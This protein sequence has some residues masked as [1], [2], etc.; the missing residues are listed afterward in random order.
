MRFEPARID[1]RRGDVV[2]F[3]QTGSIPHNVQ[4]VRNS[5]PA[6][7]DIGDYWTGPYLTQPGE[8]YELPIDDPA[9]RPDPPSPGTIGLTLVTLQRE[10]SSRS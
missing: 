8:V 1:A 4:F 9:W 10:T 5:A 6:G 3:V 7:V 2:R